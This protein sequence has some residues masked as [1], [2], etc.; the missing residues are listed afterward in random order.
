MNLTL[1]ETIENHRKLWNWIADETER[2]KRKVQKEEYFTDDRICEPVAFGCFCCHYTI[3]P[4]DTL[5]YVHCQKCPLDWNVEKIQYACESHDALYSVWSKL[6]PWK[7]ETAAKLAREIANLPLK[8][9]YQEQ[10]N[11][12]M[13][14]KEN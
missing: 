3:D 9:E 6:D 14:R 4:D 10:L 1:E 12:K 11:E 7:W 8:A 5:K 13:S 2:K